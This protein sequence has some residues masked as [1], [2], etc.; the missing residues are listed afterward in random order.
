MGCKEIEQA[1]KESKEQIEE[2]LYNYRPA[3]AKAKVLITTSLNMS[4]SLKAIRYNE[5][6]AKTN[7][8]ASD[9]EN[10][11][12]K[13]E[14]LKERGE[15]ILENV[16]T[17]EECLECLGPE[18]HA[19]IEYKYFDGLEDSD[20]AERLEVSIPTVQ[21]KKRAALDKLEKVGLSEIYQEFITILAVKA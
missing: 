20:S 17:I 19:V 14:E 3:K 11:I 4:Y 5:P 1:E 6:S 10:Y 21:N 15:M 16:E 2:I 9:T 12:D 18:E 13:K 8:T 7:E